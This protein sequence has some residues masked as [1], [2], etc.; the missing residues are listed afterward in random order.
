MAKASD[1]K[2][3]TLAAAATCFAS[4]AITVPRCT[5]FWPRQ[6]LPAGRFT[7]I[8]KGQGADRRGRP[9]AAGGSRAPGHRPGRRGIG[10]RR[11]FLRG[12]CAHGVGSRAL[13]LPGRLPDRD[14]RAGNRGAIR[15]VG[16][17]D[18]QRVPEMGARDQTRAVPPRHARRAMRTWSRTLVL[19]QLEGALL[20]ARTYRS[21]EPIHRAEHAV[22]LL[23]HIEDRE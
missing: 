13:R 23:A 9:G 16:R 18:P 4:R 19:S 2:G 10:E 6:A 12:S 11:S 17:R 15:S 20:L 22:K 1:S 3:K 14:H 21:L 7:S 8:S 5:T